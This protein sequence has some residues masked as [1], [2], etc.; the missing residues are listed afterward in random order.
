MKHSRSGRPSAALLVLGSTV[1]AQ[2]LP[3]EHAATIPWSAAGLGTPNA[4]SRTVAAEASGDG[5][6]DLFVR[7]GSGS[8]QIVFF[9]GIWF[10]AGGL[11][12]TL[13]CNDFDVAPGQG[14]SGI[15]ALAF[16]DSTGLR[17]LMRNSVA[18]EQFAF[19]TPTTLETGSW[20]GAKLVRTA[21]VD[22]ANGLDYIGVK[23]D[24]HTLILKPNGGTTIEA[25]IGSTILDVQPLQ[26]GPSANLEIAVLTVDGLDIRGAGLGASDVLGMPSHDS[27]AIAVLHLPYPNMDRLAWIGTEISTG[28]TDFAVLKRSI[29][30]IENFGQLTSNDDPIALTSGDADGDGDDDLVVS[31]STSHE[32]IYLESAAT[33]WDMDWFVVGD[34]VVHT[35]IP[36]EV[37]GTQSCG[38]PVMGKFSNSFGIE[39]IVPAYSSTEASFGLF[40]HSAVSRYL[41]QDVFL[42]DV[43]DVANPEILMFH[44]SG[45]Q[46]PEQ[47][48][49]QFQMNFQGEL[50]AEIGGTSDLRIEVVVFQAAA[51]GNN[52]EATADMR[53]WIPWPENPD[54]DLTF[55]GIRFLLPPIDPESQTDPD[56]TLVP[57][58]IEVRQIRIDSN[59]TVIEAT[60]TYT[61]G[62]SRHPDDYALYWPIGSSEGLWIKTA[63]GVNGPL[64][65]CGGEVEGEGE[66]IVPDPIHATGFVMRRKPNPVANQALYVP[67][68]QSATITESES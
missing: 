42:F 38:R 53:Y 36:W 10:G 62:I 21:D 23:A 67:Y 57:R 44:P 18:T 19:E 41:S 35:T 25:D 50:L 48:E 39:L 16:V 30:R 45:S 66:E 61:F 40:E 14:P 12:T 17:L 56:C 22:H 64:I 3:Y 6:L 59:N 4:L 5:K 51:S 58:F 8:A 7:G 63:S 47:R 60:P 15:A 26:W 55:H 46:V 33:G 28:D 52:V 34:E 24:G 27:K 9:D 68:P 11:N 49:L 37:S 2:S 54:A 43:N 29:T 65:D 31:L 20:A 1:A 32:P 13:T